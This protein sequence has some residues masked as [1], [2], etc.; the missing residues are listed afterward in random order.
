MC[1]CLCLCVCLCLCLCVSVCVRACVCACVCVCVCVAVLSDVRKDC[2]EM[3]GTWAETHGHPW[4]SVCKYTLETMRRYSSLEYD[5]LDRNCQHFVVA[6]LMGRCQPVI[7][8]RMQRLLVTIAKTSATRQCMCPVSL[9]KEVL[10]LQ[11]LLHEAACPPTEAT[12]HLMFAFAACRYLLHEKRRHHVTL[13]CAAK[14]GDVLARAT[15]LAVTH[16]TLRK[17]LATAEGHHVFEV[18]FFSPH[19]RA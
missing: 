16:G 1:L 10:E 18:F 12:G 8:L 9:A 15:E 6:C 11:H 17:Q 13:D 4:T 7:N 2:Y 14:L 3:R 19:T 5:R